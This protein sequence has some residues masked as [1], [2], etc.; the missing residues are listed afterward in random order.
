MDT[1]PGA[2]NCLRGSGDNCH[3]LQIESEVR[4][5]AWLASGVERYV[6]V[7]QRRVWVWF[8]LDESIWVWGIRE[9]VL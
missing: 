4:L 2:H 3:G 7:G 9:I 8:D 1:A 5:R 6:P